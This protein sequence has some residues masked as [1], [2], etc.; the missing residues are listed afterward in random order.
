MLDKTGTLTC[1]E[2]A[3]TDVCA[4][5]GF[6]Q[7]RV[8]ALAALASAEGGQ[9]PVDA[10]VRAAAAMRPTNAD[11]PKVITFVPFDPATKMSEAHAID[12]D[13]GAL[14]IVKGAFAVVQRLSQPSPEA[15]LATNE[16]EKLGHRVLGVA[17]GTRGRHARRRTCG[18]E[19]SAA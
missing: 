8:L 9:D 19:R 13:G 16:L 6:D 11:L 3:V 15:E 4:M 1:N 5:P 7:D 2:L 18:A 17:V 14:R 10:A 12:R